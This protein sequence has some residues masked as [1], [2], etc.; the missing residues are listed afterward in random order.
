M[1]PANESP[2]VRWQ[3]CTPDQSPESGARQT[4][5]AGAAYVCGRSHTVTR[6]VVEL[7]KTA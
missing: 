6:D 7:G 5:L 4:L 1:P 3:D 2:V